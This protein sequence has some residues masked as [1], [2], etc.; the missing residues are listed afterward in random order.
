M[1]VPGC[2]ITTF[3]QPKGYAMTVSTTNSRLGD[4]VYQ[5]IQAEFGHEFSRLFLVNQD[6]MLTD[7]HDKRTTVTWRMRTEVGKWR[8]R[9]VVI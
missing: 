9:E 3:W 4:D 6:P 1:D 8:T 5:I 2:N 7:R